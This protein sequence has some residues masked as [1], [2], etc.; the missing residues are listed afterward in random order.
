M[1]NKAQFKNLT[2][3]FSHHFYDTLN[4]EFRSIIII[5]EHG[6]KTLDVIHLINHV[7]KKL[8][9]HEANCCYCFP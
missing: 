4:E 8:M 3:S 5:K 1:V 9:I 2:K 6:D 7:N